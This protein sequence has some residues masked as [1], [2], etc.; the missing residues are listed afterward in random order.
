[1]SEH[2]QDSSENGSGHGEGPNNRNDGKDP[3]G[4][5]PTPRK[6]RVE[7]LEPRILMS[8]TWVDPET[9]L[10]IPGATGGSDRF[11]GD[12][13]DDTADG[14]G[15]DDT[16]LGGAGDDILSGGEGDDL[17]QGGE[18]DDTLEGDAGEDTLEGD[19]GE[20]TLRGG[21]NDDVLRGGDDADELHGGEGADELYGD[22]GA[23]TLYG[24]SGNDILEGLIGDDLLV[25]GLGDDILRGGA[26]FD[27]ADYSS[28]TGPVTIDLTITTAQDT[29]SAGTD[30][31]EDIERVI[32]T[33]FDDIFAF[34]APADGT[35]YTIEGGAGYNTVDLSE[36]DS[37]AINVDTDSTTI[38]IDLEG[39]GSFTID[40]TD[41]RRIVT[42]DFPDGSAPSTQTPVVSFDVEESGQI[43]LVPMVFGGGSDEP[44]YDW[45]VIKGSG[46][47]IDDSSA[48]EPTLSFDERFVNEEATVRLTLTSPEGS[49][50]QDIDL[51]IQADNDGVSIDAMNVVGNENELITLSATLEDPEG[52]TFIYSWEQV[53]NGAPS[54][55]LNGI[56]TESPSFT[57]PELL[58]TTVFQFRITASDGLTETSHDVLVTVNAA[59]DPNTADAGADR[60]VQE[61]AR[62][63]TENA[64]TLTPT[65]VTLQGS[66]TDPENQILSYTWNQISGP[67]V[68]LSDENTQNPTFSSPQGTDD[69]TLVF[70]VEASDGVNSSTDQVTIFIQAAD[71]APLIEAI[72]VAENTTEEVTPMN[73]SV[74]ASD[75]EGGS[76]TY[77]WTQIGG[78][79]GTIADPSSPTTT[80][81]SQDHLVNTWV[82][83]ELTVSDGVETST[84]TFPILVNADNDAPT[85]D[86]GQDRDVQ[87]GGVVGLF[88]DS[89]DPEGRP[90]A[91]FWDQIG[92]PV[93]Q[94]VD[95][96]TASPQFQAPNVAEPTV[97]TFQ[98]QAFDGENTSV[99]TVRITI[100]PT[101]TNEDSVPAE[102]SQPI[103]PPPPTE[104][105]SGP[106]VE[107]G[108]NRDVQPE[109]LVGLFADASDPDN[110]PL[111]YEWEQLSGPNVQFFEGESAAPQFEA[112][113]VTEPTVLTFQV[114]VSDG[115]NTAT[116][117]ITITVD[118]A[119]PNEDNIP[120]EVTTP[121]DPGNVD[122]VA[123][124][125]GATNVSV[126]PWTIEVPRRVDTTEDTPTTV[127]AILT[128]GTGDPTPP[129]FTWTQLEGT[130]VVLSGEDTENLSF[131]APEL[132][133]SEI[134]IFNLEINND[135][136][137][138]NERVFVVVDAD[139]DAP[140]PDA[141]PNQTVT[142]D[143]VVTLGAQTTEIE[144]QLV[145]QGWTQVSGPPVIWLSDTQD[146]NAQFRPANT[147][148]DH[149]VVLR[150]V[151]DDGTTESSSE[152]TIFVVADEDPP[153]V[154]AG[155]DA[156]I[157]ENSTF[158]FNPTA[159]DPENDEPLSYTWEQIGGDPVT[160]LNADSPNASFEAT[161][162]LTDGTATFR[163]SV[164]DGE[165][166][167]TDEITITIQRDDDG[168]T[169]SAG[170]DLTV[171]EEDP[172]VLTAIA[173]DPEGVDLT[174][175]WTQLNG[176]TVTLNN[177]DTAIA[178][179]TAPNFVTNTYLTF[180]VEVSDGVT[181]STDT[182]LVLVVADN[183]AP[184]IDAGPNQTVTE[185]D[186]VTLSGTA[187]EPEG[188]DMRHRWIQID[189]GAPTVT[190]ASSNTLNPTFEAP[191]VLSSETL[192][193]QLTSTDGANTVLDTV[194]ITVT[195]DDD[196]AV[197][198][199]GT[200]TGTEDT[201]LPI[202]LSAEDVDFGGTVDQWR[203][204]TLPTDGVLKA[205]GVAV[206]A[207]DVVSSTAVLTFEPTP[208][209]AG[210]TS[211]DFRA[212]DDG[213][214][215]S[216]LATQTLEIAA[217]ADDASITVAGGTTN[218]DTSLPIPFSASPD[219][220]D[221]SET[222][223]AI[224]ISSA[225]IGSTITDGSNSVE[226]TG[227]PITITG[228]DLNDLEFEPPEHASG[229]MSVEFEV[230]TT[231]SSN[232]DSTT[233]SSSID[234]EVLGVTDAPVAP[235]SSLT[236]NEDSPVIVG[237]GGVFV[238]VDGSETQTLTLSDLPDGTT[239][240]DGSNSWTSTGTADVIDVAGWDLA[241][242]TLD[243]PTHDDTDFTISWTATSLD[244]DSTDPAESA[245]GTIAITVDAVADRP[246]L[247]VTN[248]STDEDI[249][250]SLDVTTSLEDT[251]GSET[252]TLT[253]T[254]IPEGV[255]IFD[256]SDPVN[257]F[258]GS[259]GNS[260]V[261]ISAW[262]LSS[263]QLTPAEHD[264]TDFSLTFTSTATEAENGDTRARTR[265]LNVTVDPLPD[266]P[267]LS[268]QAVSTDEDV[269]V[270]I[271]LDPALVDTDGSETLT[272]FIDHVPAG[273]VLSD[274]V[275]SHT[276]TT[277]D[278]TVDI[279]GWSYGDL[280][281]TPPAHVDGVISMDVR[282]VSTEVD[283]GASLTTTGSLD[284]TVG[285][286]PDAPTIE[287]SID[288]TEDTPFDLSD[289][290]SWPDTDGSETYTVILSS[291][292]IG[293][294][295]TDG[296]S[297]DVT[298][299]DGSALDISSWDLDNVTITP[300]TNV[301]YDGSTTFHVQAYASENSLQSAVVDQDVALNIE[302]VADQPTLT[303]TDGSDLE[304][305]QI[306]FT[307]DSA[308]TDDDGSETL[309]VEVL[310][311]PI[312]ATLRD[313]GGNEFT[314]TIGTT[315]VDVTSWDHDNLSIQPPEHSGDDFNLTVRATAEEGSNSDTSTNEV[316]VAITVTAVADLPVP[317][318]ND[319]S[320]DEDT[321]VDLDLDPG[322]VDTDGSES[323]V[324]ELRGLPI[325]TTIQDDDGR[326]FTATLGTTTLDI[327]DWDLGSIRL[328]APTHSDVDF[329]A[330]FAVRSE[331]AENSDQS[332]EVTDTFDVTVTAVAD[333]PNLSASNVA[334]TEDTTI[335]LILT[336]SLVDTDGTETLTLTASGI[337]DGA[338]LS[339]GVNS[340]TAGGGN[341]NE[342]DI[343]SWDLAALDI[344]PPTHDGSNISLTFTAVS[345]EANGGDTATDATTI[346]VSVADSAD[347]P[348]LA[349]TSTASGAE[350]TPIP[351]VISTQELVDQDGSESLTL[352]VDSLPVGS[353]VT[354]G[355]NSF[356]ATGGNTTANISG[357]DLES[358]TFQ[359]TLHSD[360]DPVLTVRARA[361]EAENGDFEETTAT[362]T[363]TVTPVTDAL[364]ITASSQIGAE[365]AAIDVPIS[366]D[367][368]DQDGSESITSILIS[369]IPDGAV[370]SDGTGNTFT[371]SSGNG[372]EVDVLGWDLDELTVT[373]PADDD[374][375]FTLH[376]TGESTESDGGATRTTEAD[377]AVTVTAV[378][379]DPTIGTTAGAGLEEA[380]I[381]FQIDPQLTDTDGSEVLTVEIR[382][383]PVGATITDGLGGHSFTA[384]AGNTSV[385]VSD[386]T[387]TTLDLTPP[388]HVGD[389]VNL[390]IRATSTETNGGDT[391]IVDEN[392]V[393]EVTPVVDTPTLTQ[394]GDV[395]GDEDA[396][397]D[398]DLDASLVDQD[399]SETLRME[400]QLLPEGAELRDGDS[401]TATVG[402]TGTVD[403]SGWDLSTLE[404]RAPEHSDDDFTGRLAIQ[405]TE[406]ETGAQSPIVT[407]DFNVTV[408]AV[409][410]APNLSAPDVSGDEDTAI[411]IPIT[412]SLVDPDNE[413][414]TL[415]I[416]GVP[417]GATIT[418][419]TG[420]T[421]TASVGTTTIE[422]TSWE[423]NDLE[424][425]PPADND[426]DF[427]LTVVSTSTEANGG[428]TA[429]TTE[430]LSV[431]VD[432]VADDPS[433]VVTAP[434][435]TAEDVPFEFQL[436][437]LLGET[438]GSEVLTLT[439]EG[440]PIG[441]TI[442][443]GVNT[444]TAWL[445]NTDVEISSWDWDNLSIVPPSNSGDD[446]TIDLRAVA[447]ET[448]NG[449]TA[450]FVHTLDV[451][452]YATADTPFV[453]GQ[454]VTGDEDSAIAL[455]IDAYL[456][457]TDGSE[458]LQVLISGIP[459]GATLSDGVNS[460]TASSDNTEVD[461][462]T[463]SLGDVTLTPPTHDGDPIPLTITAISTE[464][465]AAPGNLPD[466]DP[467]TAE[468]SMSFTVTVTPR[469]DTPILTVDDVTVDEDGT[470]ALDVDFQPVDTDGSESH[471]LTVNGLPAGTTLQGAIG[472]TFVST[473]PSEVLDVTGWDLDQLRITPP[474]DGDQDFTISFTATATE[475]ST[476]EAIQTTEDLTVTVDPETDTTNL[477]VG[478][479][480]GGEDTDIPFSIT[481]SLNDTDGSETLLVEATV[482]AGVTLSDGVNS[483]VS[484]GT[485]PID[486]SGWDRSSLTA[487]P[488]LH[489]DQDFQIQ[490]RSWSVES[491][492]GAA[493]TAQTATVNITVS[494]DADFVNLA[495]TGA[496]GD[497]DTTIPLSVTTSLVD[498]DGS[499]TFTI[500]VQDIPVGSVLEAGDGQ[501]FTAT[502]G[503]TTADVTG[504]DLT[505][506]R[507]TPP[508]HDA[509]DFGLTF[510]VETTEA[511]NGDTQI[512]QLGLPVTVNAVA[513][514]PYLVRVDPIQG[515]EDEPIMFWVNALP[516]DNDGSETVTLVAEGL[517]V[518][519]TL[520]SGT[521]AF[522]A[523]LG[524]TSV[525]VTDW[526]WSTM[527]VTPPADSDQDFTFQFRGTSTEVENGDTSEFVLQTPV[528]VSGVADAPTLDVTDG[529]GN[530]DT[531]IPV[532]I[533]S[534]LVDTDGSESLTVVLSAILEG[535]TIESGGN[536]FTATDVLQSVDVTGWDLDS[537]EVT[538]P[539]NFTGQLPILVT[540]TATEAEGDTETTTDTLYVAVQTVA[541]A[542]TLSGSIANG[543]EDSPHRLTIGAELV[544]PTVT[545]ALTLELSGLP[546]GTTVTDGSNTITVASGGQVI[547]ITGF[548]RSTLDVIPPEH[549]DTV[550]TFRVTATAT[551][552][553]NGS[554]ATSE[555]DIDL[556]PVA[557]ADAPT[558]LISPSR[559]G[560]EDMPNFFW[561]DVGQPDSDG[562][563]TLAVHLLDLP[564][565][566]I[567][568]DGVE[569]H[570][571]TTAGEVLEI[572]DWNR[573]SLTLQMPQDFSGEVPLRVLA[574][575]TEAEGGSTAS[576]TESFS[577]LYTPVA[578]A[579]DLAVGPAAGDEDTAIPLDLSTS[580]TD[581]D[582]SETLSLRLEG[583]PL[584]S[585]ISDGTTTVVA[586]VDDATISLDGFDLPSLTLTP[587]A[588]A[589]DDITIDV[590]ATS[591]EMANG[592]TTEN[593][594]S[595]TIDVRPIA[596]SVRGLTIEPDLAR[597]IDNEPW[598]P[599]EI[600][601]SLETMD[602][603]GSEIVTIRIEG[604][605]DGSI[606]SVGEL[607]EDGVLNL[608]RAQFESLTVGLPPGDDVTVIATVRVQD[609]DSVAEIEQTFI[610]G[611]LGFHP[612]LD[613]EHYPERD[614]GEFAK[615]REHSVGYD[616]DA[617][618]LT[619]DES[620]SA[621]DKN[622]EAR[623]G[624]TNVEFRKTETFE[625]EA[626]TY[627]D[628]R[629]TRQLDDESTDSVEED[630]EEPTDPIPPAVEPSETENFAPQSASQSTDGEAET[631]DESNENESPPDD[632][633]SGPFT[634]FLRSVRSLIQG[635][636][637][638]GDS[639]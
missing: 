581:T 518:G 359:S 496:S 470:A 425:T 231:E 75:P 567:L 533:T 315:S 474:T 480:S 244:A 476:G 360:N 260:T 251:D 170:N 97:L 29:G 182:V 498:D 25:G 152:V 218:E 322:L 285:G 610:F 106:S 69:L 590:V 345:T 546:I 131:Q 388:L 369:D 460:V 278:E 401:N 70:E 633:K 491:D 602:S 32:G 111:T 183:D 41:V 213:G 288:G 551:D 83:L 211:F 101:S 286:I 377:L 497:E 261:D 37:S 464:N 186:P 426:A 456:T 613:P 409:A 597:D 403:I 189:N 270:A 151:T 304:D 296:G 169:V 228:W 10:V 138:T 350:D 618:E 412:T 424:I 336:S 200:D 495:V 431:T 617:R 450:E 437:A 438:D 344:T 378:A 562:S 406:T 624:A 118:P 130:P 381:S 501:S 281:F 257:E 370:L 297:N 284:V 531:A 584:G 115:E 224:R 112:P 287:N 444:F 290:V 324:M 571:V 530:E 299:V 621:L 408:D 146:P 630:L 558:I 538:P 91:Y 85:V 380:A 430:T 625:V 5:N 400:L 632:E 305:T 352:F 522:T 341:G 162:G 394:A 314:A 543:D 337:P 2:T 363:V 494:G 374:A 220:A 277:A 391:A 560:P 250:V 249:T 338:V 367:L 175:S 263:L 326:T 483:A 100:D 356:T 534:S 582:G 323:A 549:S 1:M 442:R 453:D 193:F 307:I 589:G 89:T 76:L 339:D 226:F 84:R 295:I 276:T 526:N 547:D 513:D 28:A 145:T 389:D 53:D 225:P 343:E 217:V 475:D 161:E 449:D 502:L 88:A 320:V 273:T 199:D 133:D 591:T 500:E 67:D 512:T 626:A 346:T 471:T 313:G 358:L 536:S 117:T 528:A 248:A 239:L 227:S 553:D 308:L 56:F 230:D 90:L 164:T 611:T 20:D 605:P 176:P 238:D 586:S 457:D 99:D 188:Q 302:A 606:F 467:D 627:E 507:I 68:A 232:G 384:T 229:D 184:A 190:L 214:N 149:T 371:A 30:T 578:D 517:P 259:A 340:F 353:T 38:S 43:T 177:D 515:N 382:D 45:Q 404:L 532:S 124:N 473:G 351:L 55:A 446:F 583:I 488:V 312:G 505:Q 469:P 519:S 174:Y 153:T 195:G 390:T 166:T 539:E 208:D 423:L 335:P 563:E 366:V 511:E 402:A 209:W 275:N 478:D 636:D 71:D 510:V 548:D 568:S 573:L 454:D 14:L 399:G 364:T 481:S 439:A 42:A 265:T 167:V 163:V 222:I 24:D 357:W 372:F 376:I 503:S 192:I 601:L 428:D 422:V 283:G 569:T 419:G 477:S 327:S 129:T 628:S 48:T 555:L 122:P 137:T 93:V 325:G 514:E 291:L 31:L 205:D 330:T 65:V 576:T 386:W 557:V 52:T 62:G 262:D 292:P 54:V 486:L 235:G 451:D 355:V 311:V 86:L 135:G 318:A 26:D 407:A 13:T 159:T 168:P 629:S 397:I 23:D 321:F 144:G 141:G 427:D 212:I 508:E 487:T 298:T 271:P 134:L 150:W 102:I 361:T 252:L 432:A 274:G 95:D 574:T 635:G 241:N 15:G 269:E 631:S 545:E 561:V 202:T 379:D 73:L 143:A 436:D 447:T 7:P 541:D 362:I 125:D 9:D 479:G 608:T 108:E 11:E 105:Y 319:V 191:N 458:S 12:G 373:P 63:G 499:E 577:L 27:T 113:S 34:T 572:S 523:T 36:F 552:S 329:T 392:L 119:S 490:V 46:I 609:G 482:P 504:W 110:D 348:S 604:L 114:T 49:T 466:G 544:D 638:N 254:G 405:S 180:Q 267:T 527:T 492:G 559:T 98:V 383:I 461:V 64:E 136:E 158:V 237:L 375:D 246:N 33:A 172:V 411:A 445:G 247:S 66:G 3:N 35:T 614:S 18:D 293:S 243:P 554:T 550:F 410:D 418:D 596:D 565:G 59:N 203:V 472:Q 509:T 123:S 120:P 206:S 194:T 623:I 187:F 57:A 570:Q 181:T 588:E 171:N 157:N 420:N 634:R 525:D 443:D 622:D 489:D 204:V 413:T 196:A 310:G 452:V 396:W 87:P 333:T 566:S 17:L 16:L 556:D 506:L 347:A 221:G 417:V 207:D 255:R 258:T 140:I 219:D 616:R 440:L 58:T 459:S 416:Q 233:T 44:S 81:T 598:V 268:D 524:N 289:I 126:G 468:P 493:S 127:S 385:E 516:I 587:P 365:D 619:A 50:A 603:D 19:G 51:L 107:L 579:P 156:T 429:S 256:G 521:E 639:R 96:G 395:Q 210:T 272:V 600:P 103:D 155:P 306:S 74:T 77:T 128:G 316:T 165:F 575:S 593:R 197:A 179:F 317:V 279:S 132:V 462:T 47:S 80:F 398:L 61:G 94:F 485:T 185:L 148:E 22:A 537:L 620:D 4:P 173:N 79:A 414:L 301:H 154:D 354:D 303:K 331:E 332:S 8:G 342:V 433:I 253:V 334:G 594:L 236:T 465:E 434:A 92:G 160:L 60:T 240:S 529:S 592:D 234:I 309:T 540:S 282:A 245:S 599:M 178:D 441:A 448:E 6:K 415:Q 21:D 484:D 82:E 78:P 349:V 393:L 580:L 40:Y 216:N 264:D 201:A 328:R 300:P 421:F 266:A 585:T 72:S 595:L 280:T 368:I 387:L 215:E 435:G 198:E 223:T 542:P 520:R 142:E 116:D 121:F 109:G 564:V 455:N 147:H 612:L 463:W 607:D 615:P 139:N 294:R 535:T 637:P 242:L 39:G 104:P